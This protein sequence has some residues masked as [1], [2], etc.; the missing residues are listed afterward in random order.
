MKQYP[1]ITGQI[2]NSLPI[3]AFDKLDGSN[4]RAE[5]HPKKGFWKFGSRTQLIDATN[6][7][8]KSI[9]LIKEQEE[10]FTKIFKE[11]QIKEAT[12]FFEFF[13]PSSFAGIH[14]W[15]ENHQIVL[16]DVTIS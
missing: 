9:P 4:I 1:S 11:M 5:W 12:C 7:L 16:I 14:N 15:E 10:K 3:Y 8:G 2:T 13:G 6:P